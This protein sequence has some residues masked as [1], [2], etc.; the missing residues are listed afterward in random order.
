MTLISRVSSGLRPEWID[1]RR[2]AR[3]VEQNRVMPAEPVHPDGSSSLYEQLMAAFWSSLLPQEEE[4]AP[5]REKRAAEEAEM[6]RS[7]SHLALELTM[8]NLEE[9]QRLLKNAGLSVKV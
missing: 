4:S 6:S 1:K 5:E 3:R 7:A 2:S 9:K 8:L